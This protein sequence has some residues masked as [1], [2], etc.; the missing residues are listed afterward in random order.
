MAP[1]NGR[2]LIIACKVSV[3]F[4]NLSGCWRS[5]FMLGLLL[6]V[7]MGMLGF[8][9]AA[10]RLSL[11][12]WLFFYRVHGVVPTRDPLKIL[13]GNHDYCHVI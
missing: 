2:L 11:L 6:L 9:L 8:I 13:E 3:F 1:C 7:S 12:L 10:V 5:C 4:I